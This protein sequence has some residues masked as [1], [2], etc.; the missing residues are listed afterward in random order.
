[1]FRFSDVQMM[2]DLESVS[3]RANSYTR[4]SGGLDLGPIRPYGTLL[5]AALEDPPGKAAGEFAARASDFR[6]RR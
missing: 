5:A 1:M 2:T 4:L 6:P 3:R